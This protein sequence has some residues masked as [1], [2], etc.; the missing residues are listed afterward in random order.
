MGHVLAISSL[1]GNPR[2]VLT[3]NITS[4]TVTILV[5]FL[6]LWFTG[7]FFFF[8]FTKFRPQPNCRKWKAITGTAIYIF[9]LAKISYHWIPKNVVRIT[10]LINQQLVSESMISQVL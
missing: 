5:G 9:E 4:V 1:N 8:F 6:F 7:F 3:L 2:I 10:T